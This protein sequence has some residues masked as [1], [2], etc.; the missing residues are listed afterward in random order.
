MQAAADAARDDAEVARDLAALAE[1]IGWHADNATDGFGR[2]AVPVLRRWHD[3]LAAASDRL[4]GQE[5]A[6]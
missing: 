3:R 1:A 6:A 4:S 5:E 2:V